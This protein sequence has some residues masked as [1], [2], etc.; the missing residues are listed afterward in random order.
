MKRFRLPHAL[1]MSFYSRELYRD[2]GRN[3]GGIGLLYLFTL[4]LV[5]LIPNVV[6]VQLD[7]TDWLDRDANDVVGKI[8]RITITN[9]EVST[10]VETPYYIANP[11]PSKRIQMDLNIDYIAVI[12]VTGKYKSLEE[13]NAFILLTKKTISAR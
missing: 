4:L 7:F 3:W 12:D 8:P 9:G 6:K 11:N 13:V 1:F 10:D 5:A 2:I